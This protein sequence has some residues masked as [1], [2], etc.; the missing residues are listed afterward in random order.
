VSDAIRYYFDEH[1][2]PAIARGLRRRGIDCLTTQEVG[3]L[4]LDDTGQLDFATSEKRIM[5]TFDVDYIILH[6]GGVSHAGIVWAFEKK[7]TIGQLISK[8][9]LLHGYYSADQ[10]LN[11]LEYH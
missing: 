10:M 3:H 9:S 11:N 7:Y 5:V 2:D 6:S 4:G 8:L 1:M